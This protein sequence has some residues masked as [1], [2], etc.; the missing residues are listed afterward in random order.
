LTTINWLHL[1]DWHQ[2]TSDFDRKIVREALLKDI[3]ERTKIDPALERIDLTFFTGDLAFSGKEAE[4]RAAGAE[5]LDPVL[6]AV[7]QVKDRLFLI[8][9][10]HDL[11]RDRFKF[12]PDELKKPFENDKSVQEWVGAEE[13]RNTVLKPFDAYRKFVETYGAPGFSSYGNYSIVEIDGK[14]IG[15]AGVNSAL[16]CGRRKNDKG[17]IDD[18]G[19]LVVGEPQLYDSLTAIGTADIRIGLIHHP[20]DWLT[21]F[22]R[23]AIESRMRKGCHFILRGHQ[24]I[25]DVEVTGGTKGKCIIIPGGAC[26]DGRT[27]NRPIYANAYNFV[28]FNTDTGRGT[29][30]LRRWNDRNNEWMPD[31]DAYDKG[32]YSFSLPG[33]ASRK[34]VTTT[35][36]RSS[37]GKPAGAAV[38]LDETRTTYLNYLIEHCGNLDPRGIAQTVKN[39]TLPLDEVYISLTAER[40]IEPDRFVEVVS[41]SD[42]DMQPHIPGSF[43]STLQI[44]QVQ[45]EINVPKIESIDI[46]RQYLGRL[47]R[48]TL[49]NTLR[50][51][52]VDLPR[53]VRES[54]HLVILGDPGA[55]KTTLTK[56]LAVRF[57]IGCRDN[58]QVVQDK[59]VNEYGAA[60]LPILLR[61]AGFADALRKDHNLA[62]SDYLP[63]AFGDVPVN[64]DELA[65]LLSAAMRN[66][67]AF[68]LLDGLDEVADAGMRVEVA[69]AID[70]FVAGL[71]PNNRVLVTSRIAGYREA[72]LGA[73]FQLFTL[74]DMEIEQIDRFLERWCLACERFH[75]PNAALAQIETRATTEHNA[76]MAAV[77]NNEGV[78]RLA[79][80]PLLLTI[81][82]LIHRNSAHLPERRIELYQLAARTLLRDWRLAQAGVEARVVEE[83]EALA[84]LG[85]LAYWMHENEPTGLI[86]EDEARAQLCQFRAKVSNLNP[87]HPDVQEFVEKFLQRV[88]EHS[89]L[90]VERAPGKYGFMHLTFEE[91]FAAR[92]I[93]S[94]FTNAADLIRPHRHHP[95][96]EEPIRLAIAYESH[97]NAAHL[98]R[99]ALWHKDGAAAQ[100]GYKPSD[101]EEILR[102]DLLLAARCLGDCTAVEPTLRQE[103]ATELVAICLNRVG[104][105][106]YEGLRQRVMSTMATFRSGEVSTEVLPLLLAALK[107]R[108]KNVRSAAAEALGT[109]GQGS[110]EALNALLIALNDG[111]SDVRRAAAEA[112]GTV[113]QGST[114]VLR[115]L[116]A[117]IKIKNVLSEDR[118]VVAE[119]LGKLGQ[120]STEV[121]NALLTTIKD[122][123][124]DSVVRAPAVYTLTILA[125]GSTEA[126]NALLAAREDGQSDVRRAAARA[127]GTVGQGSPQALNALLA[128]FKDEDRFVR[129]AVAEALGKMGQGSPQ[130]LN[131]LLIALN[132]G[133]SDVRCAAIQAL[134]T[135]GQG[136]PEALNTLLVAL[137]DEDPFVR[138]AVVAALEKV[139]QGSTK[140]LNALLAAL[141]D[142][143]SLVRLAVAAALGKVG[144]GSTKALNALLAAL[145]DEDQFV[146]SSVV[147]ALGVMGEGSTEILNV[148]LT[149]IKDESPFVRSAAANVLG[150]VGQGSTKALNALLAALDDED[151]FVQSDAAAA[152]GTVGQ[153][154]IEA[155]NALLAA[156]KNVFDRVRNAVWESLWQMT[157]MKA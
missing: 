78:R 46:I 8:P 65:I 145:D 27:P 84:L 39:V 36:N 37:V 86:D 52:Q 151:Y 130:A 115:A 16:M 95:R 30:Y 83:H 80:N 101:Y 21:D 112:L 92:E 111:Q 5:L 116:L 62:L 138:L 106:E 109:M 144:Q 129:S 47:N 28:S 139:G 64:K 140:A 22:D 79:A 126:L 32:K 59:E 68:I 33:F 29:V 17:Q 41:G 71:M 3:R 149:A 58:M 147:Q 69:K 85:P 60:R 152:L 34:S 107:D 133:Q 45:I 9:G 123:D 61:V 49:S 98:I 108:N 2:R 82:A 97:K 103:V 143:S 136:S 23:T 72:R 15:L 137:K 146:T 40:E 150:K 114:E 35:R 1:S 135:V 7:K 55:G 75:R 119:T 120:G 102:R 25:Q 132:D 43:V 10:N 99:A 100:T 117:A 96:W 88:R 54:V 74:R 148:L 38:S 91:Y 24:H 13:E 66:G 56:F 156:L 104:R 19:V 141:D 154:S 131:A 6:A 128:A 70:R 153:G 67:T 31:H 118:I 4:Y 14:K 113:G 53:A 11:D 125:Q 57:A 94:D 51:E 81:L 105:R 18:Y 93:V 157:A 63:Q 77:Q 44:R 50:S 12:L 89:G 122:E 124:K 90:F 26:Y 127:L 48:H 155:V 142:E 134:S 20:F 121:L 87:H 110:T 73:G 42:I 76:I